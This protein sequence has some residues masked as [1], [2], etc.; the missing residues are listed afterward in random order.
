MGR[1]AGTAVRR[2]G[3]GLALGLALAASGAP[4]PGGAVAAVLVVAQDGSGDF[5]AIQPALDAALPGDTVRVRAGVY[6]EA[7]RFPRSGAPGSPIT[8]EAWPGERPVIDG[9]GLGNVDLV[10]IE[11]RSHLRFRG[12]ELRNLLGAK[13][14]SAIRVLGAGTDLDIR[15]HLIHDIRGTSAMAITVYGTAPTPI[16]QLVVAESEIHDCEPAPSE[17]LVLNGNVTDFEVSGNRIRDV[18]NIGIDLIGGETDVQPDPSLVARNGIVRG[19]IVE[20]ARSSY[21]GGFAA[22][23]YV[24][25]ARDVVIEGNRVRESDLGIEVGA[26][27]PGIVARNVVVRSN[28]LEANDKAG[29]VF[30]GFAASAGRVEACEFRNNTLVGNDTLGSGFGELWI[31]FASGN[32]VRNNLIAGGPAGL[33]LVSWEGNTGNSLH[34]NLWWAPTGAGAATFVWNGEE[35]AG[36]E[37]WRAATGQGASSVFA[38][39]RLVD[40]GT[41]PAPAWDSPA[42]DLGDPAT[43]LDPGETDRAGEPR[44][45]GAAVDAG[46][47]EWSCGNGILEAGELCDDG[48]ATSGDGC[49][50][51]CTPTGCGNGIATA[52]EAC[53]DGNASP[54]DCCAPDCSLEPPGSACDDGDACTAPDVCDGAGLCGAPPAPEALCRAAGRATLLLRGSPGGSPDGLLRFAW[55]RGAAVTEAEL[56][57]PA[58]GPAGAT[59]CLFDRV[60]GAPS[61]LLRA[62]LPPGGLCRGRP[63]WR[64]IGSGGH[65][66]LDRDLRR[67]GVQRVVLR[68]GGDGESR[69]VLVARGTALPLPP[70]PLAADPAVEVQLHTTGGAC[71]GTS[72]AAPTRNEPGLFKARSP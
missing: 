25:G 52:G 31:Q 54:G 13:D 5:T 34:H 57:D 51:N 22:G 6:G 50:A 60:G 62:D 41:G 42:L 66:Y 46:A 43:P 14:A 19:N 68:P 53:D 32:T 39:P 55:K 17:A 59:L 69:A 4:V 29:L 47:D 8:L 65:R 72:F 26:E 67:A 40:P 30:G 20:R 16:S 24:D 36:F 45:F 63:C 49:D 27:N 7:V 15:D 33:L 48:D 64:A 61:L 11:D 71:L 18:N 2:I 10:R 9:T 1:P 28:L 37:A 44:L 58:T 23:I 56:G 3:A 12:F 38:D 70:T 21:G 35:H